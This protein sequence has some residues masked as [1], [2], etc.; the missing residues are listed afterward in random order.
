[1]SAENLIQKSDA[2]FYEKI[3]SNTEGWLDLKWIQNCNRIKVRRINFQISTK[4]TSNA[5]QMG[6]ALATVARVASSGR[7]CA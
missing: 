5:F 2:F 7:E 4:S 3:A 6:V 1:M